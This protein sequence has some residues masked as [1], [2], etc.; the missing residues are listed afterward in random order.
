MNYGPI[1]RG[2]KNGAFIKFANGNAYFKYYT[3]DD[4]VYNR[5]CKSDIDKCNINGRSVAELLCVLRNVVMLNTIFNH[6]DILTHT[7]GC[8]NSIIKLVASK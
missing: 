5:K 7:L 8:R 2:G 1:S 6:I 4:L 3:P